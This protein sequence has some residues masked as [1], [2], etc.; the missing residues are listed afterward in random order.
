M[1]EQIKNPRMEIEVTLEN[2]ERTIGKLNGNEEQPENST[3]RRRTAG[4]PTWNT[5]R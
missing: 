5:G 1:Q 3:E 2:E 4:K